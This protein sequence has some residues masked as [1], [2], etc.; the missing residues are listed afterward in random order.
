M[1]LKLRGYQERAV[2][3]MIKWRFHYLAYEMGVGKTL[4]VLEYLKRTNQKGLIVAPLLVAQRTWP[5]EVKKFGYPFK[6]ALLHGPGKDIL[7]RTDAELKVVNYDGLKWLGQQIEGRGSHDLSKRVLILDESTYIKSV[8]SK[9]FQVLRR[10]Q[11]FFK[12]GIFCLS[13]TPMPNGYP[14]LW[15]QYWML[16]RGRA[17]EST[18]TQYK[19]KYFYE[20]GPPRFIISLKP[21]AAEHIQERIKP[22]TSALFAEDYVE[23]PDSTY[24]TWHIDLPKA[25]MEEYDKYQEETP[26]ISEGTMTNKL[27]QITQGALYTNDIGAFDIK[28]FEKV[29]ALKEILEL[30]NGSPVL[31]PIQ[32]R[33]EVK[34]IQSELGYI[35]LIAGGMNANEKLTI[36]AKWD[37]GEIPLLLVHPGSLSHGVNMQFGGHWIVWYGLPWSL[38]QYQQLNGRLIRPGQTEPVKIIHIS[39]RGTKDQ[40]VFEVLE[41]KDITQ[42]DFMEAMR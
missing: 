38:E 35:P 11:H 12:A 26:F 21:G 36:L 19:S 28:H 31:C 18:Y 17:L 1:L 13:G 39:A 9:R 7:L 16:D 3:D 2:E 4:M 34:M 37:R 33:F 29:N 24:T 30:A 41:K 15:T 40:R 20:S 14:D 5:A 8:S 22:L 32:F 10:A 25:V 42:T 27:R 6:V 23:M